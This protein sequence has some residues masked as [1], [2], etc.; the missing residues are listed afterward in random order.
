MNLVSM[1]LASMN[2]NGINSARINETGP[3]LRARLVCHATEAAANV[4]LELVG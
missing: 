3:H 4:A 2:L 1:N